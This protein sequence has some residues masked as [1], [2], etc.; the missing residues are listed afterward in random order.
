MAGLDNRGKQGHKECSSRQKGSLRL[1]SICIP[2]PNDEY[3]RHTVCD[4]LD[5]NSKEQ[6]LLDHKF[7]HFPP[8]PFLLCS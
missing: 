1:S 6:H 7:S 4:V 8:F 2:F 3:L 5:G